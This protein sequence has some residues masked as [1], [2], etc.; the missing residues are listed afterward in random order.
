MVLAVPVYRPDQRG[1]ILL[2]SE[3][4]LNPKIIARLKSLKLQDVWVRYPGL[5]SIAQY[6]NSAITGIRH[7]LISL[8][9]ST[10]D[11]FCRDRP[12]HVD[13]S[14]LEAAVEELRSE[15]LN[16]P[17]CALSFE[18][19]GH[20]ESYH[21]HHA[22]ECSFLTA[23]LGLRV[24]GY[25]VRQRKRICPSPTANLISLSKAAMLHDI[26]LMTLP[27]ET[28]AAWSE[29]RNET[30]PQWQRHVREGFQRVTGTIESAA[31]AAVLQHHEYFDGSGF[32]GR[33]DWEGRSIGLS[34]HN[35]HIYARI[36]TMI[37]QFTELKY[38][39]T[40]SIWPNVRVLRLL[41]SGTMCRRFDPTILS[42]FIR[43]MPAYLPGA[44]VDLTDGRSGFVMNFKPDD[45][46]CPDVAVVDDLAAGIKSTTPAYEQV[47]LHLTKGPRIARADGLDVSAD[48]YRLPERFRH[49]PAESDDVGEGTHSSADSAA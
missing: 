8:A 23:L 12:S 37:D 29:R 40:G 5:D 49:K 30:D 16:N 1:S 13:W 28:L 42:A 27:D 6:Q 17:L 2:R 32:P 44:M 43:M 38:Q 24:Q 33:A 39:P 45:P 9:E 20:A 36:L 7:R 26:G 10:L 14:L 48:N 11:A 21:V 47:S 22:A 31:A 46:C 25:L 35:I 18:Q 41:M 15:I 3:F 4:E 34:M 19:V